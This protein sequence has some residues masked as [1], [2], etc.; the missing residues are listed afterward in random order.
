[1]A[2]LRPVRPLPPLRWFGGDEPA[3]P[4]RC[5]A[6][7]DKIDEDEGPALL[8]FKPDGSAMLRF[9]AKCQETYWGL[10]RPEPLDDLDW[11]EEARRYP[12]GFRR[13]GVCARCGCTVHRG[14]RD[15]GQGCHWVN[16]AMTRC[17]RCQR[18]CGRRRFRRTRRG[19]NAAAAV[20]AFWAAYR[21][22]QLALDD[23]DREGLC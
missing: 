9:C 16:A 23:P 5:S 17:S 18:F 7:D 11:P 21:A 2:T 1:M 4:Q 6:C 12:D 8:M 15:G 20:R 14:C 19:L 13:R 22:G 10:S 3:R